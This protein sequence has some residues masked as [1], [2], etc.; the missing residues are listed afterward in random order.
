MGKSLQSSKALFS[1]SKST[2]HSLLQQPGEKSFCKFECHL[3]LLR[4]KEW[5]RL[6]CYKSSGTGVANRSKEEEISTK[7]MTPQTV[8][9]LQKGE[10]PFQPSSLSHLPRGAS[11]IPLCKQNKSPKTEGDLRTKWLRYITERQQL[12]NTYLEGLLNYSYFLYNSDFIPLIRFLN[13]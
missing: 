12:V 10:G 6:L 9:I 2:L 11:R 8:K 4:R 13:F 1:S 7:V 5:Q 3:Q